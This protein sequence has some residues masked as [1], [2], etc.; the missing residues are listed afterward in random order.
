[1]DYKN[2]IP[3]HIKKLL[4]FELV[5]IQSYIWI[6]HG[7]NSHFDFNSKDAE[8]FAE[9]IIYPKIKMD[10]IECIL[11]SF[12]DSIQNGLTLTALGTI[13]L[14]KELYG[15]FDKGY[16]LGFYW[17]S[18]HGQGPLARGPRNEA[19]A[20]CCLPSLK[21][22]PRPLGNKELAQRQLSLIALH[23]VACLH[24]PDSAKTNI[25]QVL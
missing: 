25:H 12:M 11:K 3:H 8:T 20:A 24:S 14:Y 2:S 19:S 6:N 7:T 1:M 23:F 10:N 21:I 9:G 22:G 16:N 5:T 15:N 18:F 4:R 13:K 17:K